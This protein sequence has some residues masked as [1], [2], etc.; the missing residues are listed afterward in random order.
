MSELSKAPLPS[1]HADTLAR[2]YALGIYHIMALFDG[3]ITARAAAEACLPQLELATDALNPHINYDDL[4]DTAPSE[5]PVFPLTGTEA[6]W[7]AWILQESS[8]RTWLFT[9]QLALLY[10]FLTKRKSGAC[11]AD[12]GCRAWCLTAALWRAGNAVDFAAAWGEERR[13]VARMNRLDEV[14]REAR[15]ADLDDFGRMLL[16]CYMG[17]QEARG[18]MKV[19]GG[20]VD[21][22]WS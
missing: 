4:A 15:P 11:A 13:L 10:S 17:E 20:S 14:F 19:K 6:F 18:W 22:V 3:D 1:T 21:S 9:T 2:V 7:R 5:L 8:R 16:T 12:A